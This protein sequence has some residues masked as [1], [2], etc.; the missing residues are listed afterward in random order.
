MR[1]VKR[2]TGIIV[3]VA[4]LLV[5][6]TG[7]TQA[8]GK[9]MSKEEAI[10]KYRE[11]VMKSQAGHMAASFAIIMGKV[12]YKDQLAAHV[13]ALAATTKDIVTLFPKGTDV[14]KTKALKEVWSKNDEFKKRAK[15]AE[16]KA[17]ALAKAVAAGDT[18]SYGQHFKDLGK[19]CKACH[20]DF[21]K[22]EK[23]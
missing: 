22:K 9:K 8:A 15:D 12:D 5:A 1:S 6:V 19:A 14:G 20:K 3:S 16:D 11:A 7:V 21:R 4:A 18:K 10:V 13:N 23:K 2:Y 17:N